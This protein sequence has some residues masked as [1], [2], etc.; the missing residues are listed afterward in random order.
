MD[1]K[2]LQRMTKVGTF[3]YILFKW[4]SLFN[5]K[6]IISPWVS[7]LSMLFFDDVSTVL[8]I[9]IWHQTY[10]LMWIVVLQ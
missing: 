8:L 7:F 4:E 2:K 9:P 6:P 1:A 3:I 5:T 10:L